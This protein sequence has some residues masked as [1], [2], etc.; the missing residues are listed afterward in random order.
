MTI[1]QLKNETDFVEWLV[2][3]FT[4]VMFIT[5]TTRNTYNETAHTQ[6]FLLKIKCELD[7]VA[8]MKASEH[9][10]WI[11]SVQT[12]D[13]GEKRDHVEITTARNE[14]LTGS[15][16]GICFCQNPELLSLVLLFLLLLLF[17]S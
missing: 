7:N 16:W 14:E 12:P 17:A 13:Q 1:C 6:V 11:V 5:I 3:A 9:N 10:K 8:S 15:R 4:D 2:L